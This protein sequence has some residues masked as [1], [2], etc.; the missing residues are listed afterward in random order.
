MAPGPGCKGLRVG[1]HSSALALPPSSA[2]QDKHS[3]SGAVPCVPRWGAGALAGVQWGGRQPPSSSFLLLLQEAQ[4]WLNI[5]LSREEA[6]DAYEQLAPCFQKAL[7][8]AQ[9]AQRPQLQVRSD[10]LQ[11]RC[12][13]SPC[14]APPFPCCGGLVALWP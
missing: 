3:L 5:A 13:H 9:Q 14:S 2:G 1:P 12:P 8:C 11:A 10:D 6:G 4:T 7:S